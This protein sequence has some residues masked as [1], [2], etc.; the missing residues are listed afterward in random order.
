MRSKGENPAL[1]LDWKRFVTDTWASYVENQTTVIRAHADA[2]A[3]H[4]HQHDALVM[5]ASTTTSCT[6]DL[7]IAAWDD[8]MANRPPRWPELNG[9]L[10]TTSSAATSAELLAHGDPTRLRQLGAR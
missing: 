4:H 3:V 1:L 2:A 9:L 5:A 6:D 7:D 8:Y 10:N